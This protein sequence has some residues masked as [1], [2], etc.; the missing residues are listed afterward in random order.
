MMTQQKDKTEKQWEEMT[1]IR[2]SGKGGSVTERERERN[3]ERE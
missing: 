2:V 1:K 3:R